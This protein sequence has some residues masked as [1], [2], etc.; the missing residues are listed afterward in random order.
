MDLSFVV[1][2]DDKRLQLRQN[3]VRGLDLDWYAEC[4]RQ[5][6]SKFEAGFGKYVFCLWWLPRQRVRSVVHCMCHLMD[7][8]VGN[9]KAPDQLM[10]RHET[11]ATRPV[12]NLIF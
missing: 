6:G 5:S 7:Y 9:L 1:C 12:I 3:F 8:S 10:E 11:S 2:F 4:H